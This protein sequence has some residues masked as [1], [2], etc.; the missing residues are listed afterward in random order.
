MKIRFYNARIMKLDT[1]DKSC[2]II[3]G[4][5]HTDN[6]KISYIG[7][8][9]KDGGFDREIDCKGN[10]L[11]PGFKN[12]HTHS[13]MTFLRSYADDL[14]LQEWLFNQVFPRED[15]LTPDD[16]Y[17]LSKL[18]IMEYLTSGITANFDMYF[19]AESIAAASKDTGFRTVLCGSVSGGAEKIQRVKDEYERYNK[20]D[21]LISYQLGFHAEYTTSVDLMKEIAALAQQLKAPV[22]T[23]NSETEKEVMECRERHGKTPTALFE[24]LGLL[25]YGGGG[26]H[27]VY[28]DENDLDIFNRH[29][30]WAVTNPGSNTKLASGIAP[31]WEMQKKGINLAIGTDGSASN[32]CLDMFREMFLVTGLQK[33]REKDAAVC[34]A[35]PVLYMA[36]KGGALAMGLNDSDCLAEGKNADLIM[37]DLNQP[38]MQ[39]LNSIGKNIVYSGSKSNVKMT[40]VNGKI[41][42]ED[43]Q[44]F[45]G[46]NAEDIYR[47]ANEIADRLR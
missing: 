24:E 31:I 40:M 11:M 17:S 2:P 13:A 43:G 37:I 46:E 38:N 14:P 21:E 33:L 42:Y 32:N 9:K 18:A 4:E 10:L 5:L 3:K 35:L 6:S 15:K 25:E 16:V 20:Y 44:F 41:L 27:C 47:K 23:H 39:P 29:G 28:M 1:E 36:A 26:F 22:Y 19:F 12:A 7:A 34:D 45:I 30:L 8:E